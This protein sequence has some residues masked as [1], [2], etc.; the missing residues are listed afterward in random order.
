MKAL[1]TAIFFLISLHV[2]ADY[3]VSVS[4]SDSNAG[5]LE[6]P[7]R[8]IQ[9]AASLMVP[10]DVCYI[11]AGVYRE[12]VKPKN[13]GTSSAHIT[14]KN[15]ENDKVYIVGTDSVGGWEPYK[16]GIFKAYYPKYVTQ[17]SVN[18]KMANE[19]RWPNFRGDYMSKADWKGVYIPTTGT[20]SL[21]TFSGTNF[22]QNFW[23][24]GT[25]IIVVGS[26]WI[27][28]KGSIDAS[29]GNQVNCAI[30]S[31]PWNGTLNGIYGGAGMGYIIKHLNALDTINEWHWQKDTLYYCPENPSEI[32]TL[33]FE[34]RTRTYGFDCTGKFFIDIQNIHFVWSTVS[35]ESAQGC[36]MDGGS[37]HF[38]IPFFDFSNG[39]TRLKQNAPNYGITGW[40]G[41]GLAVS[42]TGNKIKNCYV[43]NSWGDGISV[44][45]M[46]NTVQN[47]IV[48]N[49]DWEAVDCGPISVLGTG[50]KITRNT[51]RRTARSVVIN[52]LCSKTDITY[53]DMYDCGFLNQDLGITYAYHSNGDGSHI[54][55]NWA[56]DNKAKHMS[57]GIYL[58]AADT[59]YI[60]HHNVV[61]NCINGIQTNQ[62]SVNNKVYNNT[63]WGCDKTIA[64]ARESGSIENQI[65][66]N[67]LSDKSF[68]YGTTF[69]KNL[70]TS[71]PNFNDLITFDYTLKA[72]SPAIDYGVHIDGITDGYIGSAPDAGAYEYGL[73]QWIPGSSIQI[74]DVREVYDPS[75]NYTDIRTNLMNESFQIFPNPTCDKI[76]IKYENNDN[77]KVEVFNIFGQKIME[78]F[79]CK[80]I[81]MT[82]REN[83][84]YLVVLND[85]AKKISTSK[86]LVVKK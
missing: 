36:T 74:P 64:S 3:Y 30:R 56:H 17:L 78:E 24:G 5:T 15:F 77:I 13:N 82:A 41:K 42:G 35:F 11:K 21:A 45:G 18:K 83:G 71:A 25:A 67:N 9:K 1:I 62:P 53:N 54:A 38:P 23:K 47:C 79:N 75:G 58:D 8:T 49:C 4:G 19:A 86:V 84:L 29:N 76:Q 55:Y 43:A 68:L 50:H 44:G 10:G 61:W 27:A 6:S 85:I 28:H 2:W 40:V 51:L 12:A 39:W 81:D 32:N 63:V 73:Q 48:E 72:N 20:S 22:T 14:F 69:I 7:F 34:A 16:N 80:V 57:M 26:K 37:V 59:A 70:V 65:V 52:R 60:I 46:N 33:K 66:Q 31:S